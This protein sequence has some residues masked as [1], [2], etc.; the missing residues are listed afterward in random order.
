M[1]RSGIKLTV[2]PSN[3]VEVNQ[4]VTLRCELDPNPKPPI[5]VSFEINYLAK[6]CLLEHSNG[7]CITTPDTCVTGNNAS[8]HNETL[9]S[10]QVSVPWNWNGA[11][12][13]CQSLFSKSELVVFD[14]KVPVTSVTLTPTP[15]IALVGQQINITCTTSYCYPPAYVTWYMSSTD[16]TSLSTATKDETEDFIFLDNEDTGVVKDATCQ[17]PMGQYKCH[18]IAAALLF[19]YKRASKTDIKCSWLKHPKSAPPKSTVTMSDLYPPKQQEL[20]ES[21]KK[22]ILSAYNLERRAPIQW[23]ITH[24]KVGVEEYC[25][26]GAVTVLQTGKFCVIVLYHKMGTTFVLY[27]M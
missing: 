26:A 20:T 1:S 18:H 22:R 9:Y 2:S 6:L 5:T 12:I 8:C 27:M 16:I 7:K 10:L 11:S 21:L 24:E 25:K 3:D 14:V 19:G 15:T 4:T 17:C 13:Y 23:G